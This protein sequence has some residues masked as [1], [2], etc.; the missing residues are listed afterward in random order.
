VRRAEGVECMAIFGRPEFLPVQQRD[1][2]YELAGVR[3]FGGEFEKSLYV[4][5]WRGRR[6]RR[7]RR[8]R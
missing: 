4:K 1:S 6:L 3:G 8:R 7:A 5:G 2:I